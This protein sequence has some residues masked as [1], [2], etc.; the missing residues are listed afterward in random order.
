MTQEVQDDSRL[1]AAE[2]MIKIQ[3]EG[4][5]VEKEI[6]RNNT[7]EDILK[8]IRKSSWK[9]IESTK[10]MKYYGAERKLKKRKSAEFEDDYG[11]EEI[12]EVAAKRMRY[13][14]QDLIRE[15]GTRGGI[16]LAWKEEIQFNLK[17]FSNSHI[18]VLIKEEDVSEE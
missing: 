6:E 3:K 13:D 9:R 16:C 1:I 18:D 5:I 11:I 8:P 10:E 17:T 14:G 12:W 7:D 4:E 2:K 15:E